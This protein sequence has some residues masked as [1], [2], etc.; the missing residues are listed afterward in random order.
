MAAVRLLFEK[1]VRKLTVKDI[2]EECGITRQAF[3]YHFAD[4]P[5]LLKWILE[6][7]SDRLIQDLREQGDSENGLRYFL[8]L[9]VNIYPYV[10]R[11]LQSGYKNEIEKLIE[12]HTY[13]M[14]E[15]SVEEKGLYQNYSYVDV[16]LILRYHCQAIPGLLR[17]WTEADTRNMD[18]IVSVIYQILMGEVS[19]F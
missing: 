17:N 18:H 19:P 7:G 2:V 4:I 8:M 13:R 1:K 11:S 15:R 6:S 5:D 9:A 14:L 10:E 16:K 12:E 3:Y